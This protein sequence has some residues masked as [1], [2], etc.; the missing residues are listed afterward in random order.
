M[1][2]IDVISNIIRNRRSTFPPMYTGEKVSDELITI[3]LENANYAPTHRLTEPWRFHVLSGDSLIALSE[4]MGK[5]YIE[6]TDEQDYSEIKHKKTLNNPLKSSH[7][8]AICLKRDPQERVPEWEELA[9]LSMA[10]QNMWIS[11]SA[12]GLGCYWSSPGSIHRA[13]EILNLDEGESCFGWFYIGVPQKG[14]SLISK[15]TPIEE[16]VKWYH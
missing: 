16:K 8:I 6:N 1:N 4:F 2:D 5:L 3:L 7:V 15:R 11:A 12:L 13:Q 9:A 14:L 10:V